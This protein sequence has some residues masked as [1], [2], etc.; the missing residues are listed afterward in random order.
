VKI[1]QCHNFYQQPGGEDQVFHD[2]AHLLRAHGHEVIQFTR[3]NDAI[4]DMPAWKA[5]LNTIWN[6]ETC[7]DLRRVLREERPAVVHFT[8]TFP[9]I[10]PAAYY[11]VRKTGAKVVQSLHNYRLLCPN[12]QFLRDGRP[13]ESCLGRMIAWPAVQ[14]ACYRNDRKS[15]AVVAAM[16]TVHRSLGTWHRAVDL[17]LALTEF[18][19]RKFIEGGIPADKIVVKPNFIREDP[20]LGDGS[21][22]YAVFVGRLSPEKG[23]ETILNAWSQLKV[24]LP[25]VIAGD[26]PLADR[27]RQAAE[28]NSRIR[29]LGHQPSQRVLEIVGQAKFLLLPSLWYEGLPKIIVEAF[30]KGTPVIAS[31][32]GAMTELIEHG[33]NGMLFTPGDPTAL[34]AAVHQVLEDDATLPRMRRAARDEFERKFTAEANYKLLMAAYRRALGNDSSEAAD[35]ADCAGENAAATESQPAENLV[36]SSL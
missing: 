11:T 1:L 23:L 13:C 6:R 29:W 35:R 16:L 31:N 5:A 22:G 21:G 36:A 8:N 25:L 7:A 30:S 34:A 12:A 14:H 2:E 26:G 27:V 4:R 28:Q 33:Q 9:L 17:Y 19:R 32:L 18:G 10:S 15:T 3:H 24:D 20:S